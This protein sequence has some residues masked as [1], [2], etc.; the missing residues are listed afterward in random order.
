[1]RISDWSSDVCSSDLCVRS[2]VFLRSDGMSTARIRLPG[3]VARRRADD[4]S[5]RRLVCSERQDRYEDCALNELQHA[6]RG[7]DHRTRSDEHTAELQS[8]M[9]KSYAG[10]CLT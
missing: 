9:S 8:L 4:R 10:F 5:D 2:A 1:M 6:D 3:S 7:D